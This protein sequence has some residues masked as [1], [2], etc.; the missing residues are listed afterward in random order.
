MDNNHLLDSQEN[1]VTAQFEQPTPPESVATK[2]MGL[3]W[4]I[5]IAAIALIVVAIL[6]YP[7]LQERSNPP[8]ADTPSI[9][10]QPA[11][12][13][14]E[15]TAQANPDSAKA[16][17]DLGNTHVQAGRW[18]Q[19]IIAYQKAIE[20]DPNYQAA[21][22]NLGVVYYQQGDFELAASQYK[23][24]LELNPDDVDVAYNL[25][26][27]YLQQALS[28]GNQLDSDL[29]DEAIAQLEQVRDKAP[30]LAEAY[31]SLGVAY[32]IL[33]RNED[34]I[35]AFEAFL[36]RDSGQDSRASQEA[37]RYLQTLRGE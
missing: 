7:L 17:F 25:G 14:P 8:P 2:R 26:A 24:A 23:K 1:M 33:N 3:G 35:E 20:L 18:A 31:F 36:A 13:A 9:E 10:A 11:L 4:R 16:Q 5:A 15:A 29:L 12:I 19:A 22:A 28:D 32:S 6:A 34:G 27:L 37:E 30:D 21:Y